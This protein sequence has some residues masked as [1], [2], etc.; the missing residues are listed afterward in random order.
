MH[1]PKQPYDHFFD[2][3]GRMKRPPLPSDPASLLA[4]IQRL[5]ED[6]QRQKDKARHHQKH[7]EKVKAK[8]AVM[9]AQI[10]HQ[11]PAFES[12]SLV[13]GLKARRDAS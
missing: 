10:K 8:S 11:R 3:E 9:R 7:W 12:A 6:I 5:K 4:M 2:R 1:P 13:V